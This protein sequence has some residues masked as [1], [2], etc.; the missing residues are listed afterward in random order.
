MKRHPS[1][2]PLSRDHHESLILSRL[3]QK[4]APAYKGLPSTQDEKR[5]YAIR[6]FDSHIKPHFL[7]EEKLYHSLL[8]YERLQTHITQVLNDHQL[9]ERLFD[10]IREAATGE[11]LHALGVLL[12]KH[13]RFEERELFPLMEIVC[14]PDEL[15]GWE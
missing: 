12:E 10:N 15:A 3:L 2:V 8:H 1:L 5:E 14:T 4:D 13:I 7:K 9:L 6:H 11:D